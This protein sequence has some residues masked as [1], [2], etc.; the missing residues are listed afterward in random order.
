VTIPNAV[1]NQT[2]HQ[3]SSSEAYGVTLWLFLFQMLCQEFALALSL[4]RQEN[5]TSLLG[6][7]FS[8][9][10][11]AQNGRPYGKG[12]LHLSGSK[13]RARVQMGTPGTGGSLVSC[14]TPRVGSLASA[15]Q[16]TDRSWM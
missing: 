6:E 7:P 16:A 11:G 5:E 12:G 1:S 8:F 15:D 2:V 4:E 10:L 13:S 14:V 9:S 3:T